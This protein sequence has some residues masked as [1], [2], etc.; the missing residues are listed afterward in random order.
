LARTSFTVGLS[1]ENSASIT[2][3]K[4]WSRKKVTGTSGGWTQTT[5]TS[6]ATATIRFTGTAVAWAAT[7]GPT[8]GMAT[9]SLDGTALGSVDLRA[10]ATSPRQLVVAR[11]G[12]LPGG[13][14]L[15][16][17]FPAAT[18]KG[19]TATSVDVDAVGTLS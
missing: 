16:I 15:V 17:T 12:L 1:Q 2:Y 6:G 11:S 19:K 8:G 4:G 14:T 3:S 9:V 18:G 7:A 10:A 5:S 13:H